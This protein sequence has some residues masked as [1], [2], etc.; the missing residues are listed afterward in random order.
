MAARTTIPTGVSLAKRER[1]KPPTMGEAIVNTTPGSAERL[2]ATVRVMPRFGSVV[3]DWKA[4][5]VPPFSW[6][7]LATA[8]ERVAPKERSLLACTVPVV[9][10]VLPV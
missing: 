7:L 6:I 3:K 4:E 9:M 10:M 5:S 8:V 1:P 2:E